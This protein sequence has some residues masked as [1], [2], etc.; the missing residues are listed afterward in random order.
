[1]HVCTNLASAGTPK[2]DARAQADGQDV[3]RRPVDQVQVEVVLELG[4]I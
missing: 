2:V 4:R 3:E 1:M